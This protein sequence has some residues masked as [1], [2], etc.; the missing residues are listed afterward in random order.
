M[1]EN[2]Q[3]TEI[4]RIN[5]KTLLSEII[6]KKFKDNLPEEKL[7]EIIK[8]LSNNLLFTLE[9]W[10]SFRSGK[11]EDILVKTYELPGNLITILDDAT[12]QKVFLFINF[13]G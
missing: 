1:T 13:K 11:S 6:E 9:D 4:S 10:K 2:T 3:L 8:Q 7:K 5:D 12:N